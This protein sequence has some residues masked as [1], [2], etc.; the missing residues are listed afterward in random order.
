LPVGIVILLRRAVPG[1]RDVS[2]GLLWHRTYVR[3]NGRS[4]SSLSATAGQIAET[5]AR[6][7]ALSAAHVQVR[8]RH[9]PTMGILDYPS[10]RQ[11][12]L[13]PPEPMLLD[14][15]VI[16]NIEWVWDRIEEDTDWTTERVGELQGTVGR[17]FADELLALG[18]LVSHFQWEG[19]PWVVSASARDEFERHA[20]P[21]RL[22]LLSGWTRLAQAQ[23]EWSHEAFRGAAPSV[24]VPTRGMRIHPL[25]LRGLG[26][27]SVEDIVGDE[28][29]LGAFPDRGDRALIRDALL[30]GVP[31]ILTTD[32]RTFW[33]R[34]TVL[35]ALGLEVW[36][37]TDALTA[38]L[39]KWAA[40]EEVFAKR[41]EAQDMHRR[42]PT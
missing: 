27:R 33:S 17:K 14:T 10:Q 26:V 7:V 5:D 28:G 21:K 16:Q 18:G 20:G 9:N 23:E 1:R 42:T 32:L 6:R 15:C 31:A 25:I 38:Y 35:Y 3:G 34:R 29:P 37:P 24:L 19:F 4:S 40:Q 41:R 2:L 12:G 39:P 30:S 8:R 36:R 13:G 11:A 22:G